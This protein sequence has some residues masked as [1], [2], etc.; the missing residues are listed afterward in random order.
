MADELLP[1][2]YEEAIRLPGAREASEEEL[3]EFLASLPSTVLRRRLVDCTQPENNGHMCFS[4]DCYQG[5]RAVQFCYNRRCQRTVF[6][7]C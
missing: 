6:L 7:E 1:Q 5:R 2:S 3:Q 4:T